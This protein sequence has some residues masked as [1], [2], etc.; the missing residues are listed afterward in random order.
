VVL[1]CPSVSNGGDTVSFLL[2]KDIKNADLALFELSRV[3]T[4]E[5]NR[6]EVYEQRAEVRIMLSLLWVNPLLC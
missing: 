3:I 5:P 2:W 6:P 1:F 4:L